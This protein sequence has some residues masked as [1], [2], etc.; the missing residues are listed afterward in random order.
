MDYFLTSFF[1]IRVVA[2][3]LAFFALCFFVGLL[4]NVYARYPGEAQKT[5]YWVRN[6]GTTV[7]GARIIEDIIY[8]LQSG[9]IRTPGPYV[10]CSPCHYSQVFFYLFYCENDS[11]YRVYSTRVL[12]VRTSSMPFGFEWEMSSYN[13]LPTGPCLVP[14][15]CQDQRNNLISSCGGDNNVDW[16]TWN[17]ANCTGECKLSINANLGSPKPDLCPI[18]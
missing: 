3:V 16:S 12:T 8:D 1:R 17:D 15:P 5:G 4:K 10:I 11:W 7:V 2:L 14:D 6:T 18:P 13:E 9:T